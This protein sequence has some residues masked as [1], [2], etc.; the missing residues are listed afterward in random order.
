MKKEYK[1]VKFL[2]IS[3]S[4]VLITSMLIPLLTG[5]LDPELSEITLTEKTDVPSTQNTISVVGTGTVKVIPDE[6]FINISVM[7]ERPTTQEAVDENSKITNNVISVIE[8]IEAEELSIQTTGYSMNPVYDY[9][10]DDKPPAIYAYRVSAT[11]EVRTK[12]IEKLGEIISKATEAG[13]TSIS[14]IGFDLSEETKIQTKKEALTGATRDA[15]DKALAIAQS[16]GLKIEKIIYISESETLF[17]GP[18]LAPPGLGE[19]RAEEA[20]SPVILPEEI[21][22]TATLSVVYLFTE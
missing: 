6:T 9:S 20:A 11:I 15:S 12:E 10:S 7:T 5:C 17:P 13:A 21:E 8:N 2:K 18:L 4:L 22:V 14:A 1:K 19:L 3:A 16:L